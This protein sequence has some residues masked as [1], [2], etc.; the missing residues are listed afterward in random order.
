MNEGGVERPEPTEQDRQ[1]ERTRNDIASKQEDEFNHCRILALRKLGPWWVPS[2]KLTLIDAAECG[3]TGPNDPPR[4]PAAVAY[5]VKRGDGEERIDRYVREVEGKVIAGER[6]EDV[7]GDL[8]NE[9]HPTK[10]IEVRGQQ[11]P[12]KRYHVYWSAV[13]LYH[14]QSAQQ[15]AENR[16]SRERRKA[17]RTLQKWIDANPLLAHAGLRP[18]D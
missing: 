1:N 6:Y 2:M 3:P 17:E 13:E 16:V 9:E 4:I 5:K 15:L 7:F 18:E 11:V 10:R 14:P 12:I 8:L